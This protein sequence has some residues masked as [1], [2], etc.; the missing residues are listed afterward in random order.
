VRIVISGI[1]GLLIGVIIGFLVFAYTP[2]GQRYEV[3]ISTQPD[4]RMPYKYDKW[5]GKTYIFTSL[6]GY[7]IELP[8][9]TL[10]WKES[11]NKTN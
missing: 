5:T 6:A 2:I 11:K 7:W 8:K 4:H 3:L 1:I 10:S 9:E